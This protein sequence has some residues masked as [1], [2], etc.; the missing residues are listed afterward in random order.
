MGPVEQGADRPAHRRRP[1]GACRARTWSR[2]PRWTARGRCSTPSRTSSCPTT[3]PPRTTPPPP[4]TCALGGVPAFGQAQH[5][6]VDRAGPAPGDAGPP[7]RRDRG[8]GEPQRAGQPVA[9]PVTALGP[10]KHAPERRRRPVA[11]RGWSSTTRAARSRCRGPVRRVVS[12]VPSLTEAVAATAPGPARRAP[13]TGARTPPISTS[14]GSAARRTRTS[15]GSSR[16]APTS[17]LANAEENRAPRPRRAARRRRR[18]VRHRH[19]HARRRVHRR[20]AGCSPPAGSP[21]PVWLTDA[22]AAWAA[23]PEPAVRR[24]AV[25]PI[26]RRPWMAVGRDTFTGAVLARLGV[27][28]VLADDPERYP[29]IDPAALPAARPRRA[30][31]RA[32]RVHRRRR[33]GGVRAP[34]RARLGPAAHLVRAEPGRGRAGAARRAEREIVGCPTIVVTREGA[35]DGRVVRVA[36]LRRPCTPSGS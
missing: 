23:L 33:A 3:W 26:W 7:G 36:R 27:D 30:A 16:C 22:E 19:P 13:R 11:S 5:P 2:R 1:D 9:S 29:R 14:S 18:G 17:S 31:R 34:S 12:I 20:C 6:R 25:V 8:H 10:V 21:R 4:V 15:T 24:R 32:L 35:V 28:N